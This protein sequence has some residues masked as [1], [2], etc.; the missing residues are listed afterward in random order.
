MTDQPLSPQELGRLVTEAQ[1]GN[2]ESFGEIYDAYMTP[3]YRYVV[4][5]Y[6]TEL[7]EDLVADVFVKAWEK[8]HTYKER[9]G[10]PFSAWLFRIARHTL[11][12]AYRAHRGFEELN[13]ELVDENTRNSPASQTDVSFS[14]ARVRGAL[15]QLPRTY[16]EVLL[17]H[18]VAGLGHQ[19]IAQALWRTE[20]SV[21]ILKMRALKKLEALLPEYREQGNI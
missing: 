15:N 21:R 20:G 5:R 19:E 13:E 17:L 14:V 4:F 12:D 7:A 3:I 6:P 11:I 2:T 16:R 10:I 1:D 9:S 18:F 8:L